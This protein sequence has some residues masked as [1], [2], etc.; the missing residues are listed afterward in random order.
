[1][2]CQL[3]FSTW[4]IWPPLFVATLHVQFLQDLLLVYQWNQIKKVQLCLIFMYLFVYVGHS[5]SNASHSIPW[6]LK[7]Q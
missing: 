6:K 2:S 5:K 7:I 1:M 4:L 3:L